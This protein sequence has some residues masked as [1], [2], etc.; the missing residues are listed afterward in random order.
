MSK[1]CTECFLCVSVFNGFVVFWS[2]SNARIINIINI[3]FVNN[4]EIL[5]ENHF[6]LIHSGEKILTFSPS[7]F[8]VY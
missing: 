6:V 5:K 3:D 4:I 1:V 2:I 7:G 8:P